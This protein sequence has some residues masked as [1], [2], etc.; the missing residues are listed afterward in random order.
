MYAIIDIETTGGNPKKD[1][2]TEIAVLVHDG[3]EIIQSYT[4][5]INPECKIP[6]HISSL[7]GI[8]NEMVAGSP[9]FY[10]VAKELVELTTGKVFVAHNVTFDY[11]FVRSEFKRLGYDY[12]CE[13]L[14]TVR[15]SRKL[16]PGHQSYSLGRLC[17][18]LQIAINGRHRALGDAEAT[19]QLF[20]LLLEKE[21]LSD[22]KYITGNHRPGKDLHP[23]LN[24]DKVHNLPEKPGVYYF[25]NQDNEL[26]YIGK[27]K[28]I[29]ERVLTHLSSNTT[30]KAMKMRSQTADVSFETTG[31]EL[32]ALLKESYEIKKHKP[33]YNRKQRR[34]LFRYGLTY[35]TDS[36]G[37]M[38]LSLTKS[39]DITTT[40]LVCFSTKTEAQR[41]VDQTIDNYRL[42]QKLCDRY[43][44]YGHCFH[45]EIGACHGACIGQE[46][47]ENYNL[48]VLQFIHSNTF[49]LNNILIIDEGRNADEKSVVKIDN[50]RYSGYGYF[51]PDYINDDHGILHD[52]IKEQPDNR[53]VQQ[54]I[55]R[56]LLNNKVE[57]LIQY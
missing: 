26:I 2:I 17:N 20:D 57:K 30:A 41:F 38:R 5:L 24:H 51:V 47:P 50:G 32:I 15:L 27:S 25:Y 46:S 33:V 18:E 35:H 43:A 42:C 29:R 1:K 12:S 13:R 16:L 22:I 37:Y 4:T 54:I 7:T 56:Y 53:E 55:K 8:T 45:Y 44:T 11:G 3:K 28:N 10:E 31:N 52:C 23:S 39:D 49:D 21:A 6:F 34:S 48:R 36:N 14:C 19:A 9:K 40:P